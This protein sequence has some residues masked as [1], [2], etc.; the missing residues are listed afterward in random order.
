MKEFT[1]VI[2]DKEGIHARPAGELVKLAKSYASSVAVIKEGKKADAKK[3]FGLMGLGVK[4]GMEIT[5][6]VEGEDEDT[7][8]A[9]LETF[10]KD[11]L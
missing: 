6:Q 11:N 3:V 8:A 10:L 1:Y 5:V 4:Q 7:A 2:T 9:A